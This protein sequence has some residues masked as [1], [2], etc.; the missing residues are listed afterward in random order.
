MS[1]KLEENNYKVLRF[2]EKD[3][4]FSKGK[5]VIDSLINV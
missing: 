2:W 3:I 1:I 5:C 4:N